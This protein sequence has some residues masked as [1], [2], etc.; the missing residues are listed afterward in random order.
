M[1]LL[2]GGRVL[3]KRG[4]W[5]GRLPEKT[6][7]EPGGRQ[8]AA[9][10]I[11]RADVARDARRY[12]DAAALYSESLRICPGNAAIQ[13]QCGHMFKEA[14]DL[15]NAELHYLKAEQIAPGNPE[16]ALQLGHFYKVAGRVRDAVAAY[17]RASEMKPGWPEPEGELAALHRQ[18]WQGTAPLAPPM[19][20]GMGEADS[21]ARLSPVFDV[22]AA[23]LQ[24][25]AGEGGLVPEIVPRKPHEMLHAHGESIN[26][27]RF[28]KRERS[29]WGMLMTFRGVEAIRGFYVSATPVTEIQLLL[30]GLTIHR[31]KLHGGYTLEYERDNRALLK[32]V[33]NVWL[34]FSDYV[35]GRYELELRLISPLREPRIH[36]EYIV[37]AA[38]LA[39]ADH[40]DSDG[41]ITLDQGDARPVQDQVNARPSV[42]RSAIRTVLPQPPRNVLVLRTDQ[43]GDMVT[44][45]PAMQRL[46]QLLPD[47]KLVGLL[48]S[49]NA[50][51]AATLGLFDE[52]IVVDFPDDLL[53]RRRTMPLDVQ[54]RLRAR[55]APYRFDLAIDL[56]ESSMSRPL[57][58]LSGAAFLYG[59][60]DRDWPWLTAGF[61]GNTHDPK[62]DRETAPHS[63]RVLALVERLGAMLGRKAA[64]IR[65]SDLARDRLIE[66]YGIQAGDRFAV[67]HTGARIAFSRWP[68]YAEL[69]RL[70]IERT[71]L[72]VL[73]LT[74]DA[75]LR[76]RLPQ[77][78]AQSDRFRLVD[79]RLAF[80]DFDAL[81]SFCSVFVGNDSGPKHLAAL[82]GVGVVSIHSARINWNEWGQEMAGSIISRKVPC[83]GCAIYHDPDECGQDYAC[84]VRIGLDEVFDAVLKQLGPRAG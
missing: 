7:P 69:A 71:D 17:R 3:S 50:E 27:R 53:D 35:H 47:A 5:V 25:A 43:L 38:P 2:F 70:L 79:Q 58:L 73:L 59:F 21:L 74:D 67:L 19:P 1:E 14:G 49:S 75:A 8:L 22:E 11:A 65:R 63:T 52:I 23:R 16:L 9:A 44:S 34:D 12:R 37:V 61:E 60:H 45:I 39:E 82:R 64:I 81:L 15:A 66:P 41:V 36:R 40:P 46:R 68:H 77:A 28:G 56:A 18:G 29:H 55:L 62:N 31:G 42:V 24:R 51:F 4:A 84:V 33:F 6:D 32:Y 30:N 57:L 26:L 76:G 83:A 10:M 78:L 72:K 54:D 80:D 48:T 20:A 13:V